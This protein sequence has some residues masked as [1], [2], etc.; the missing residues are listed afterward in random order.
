MGIAVRK[1]EWQGSAGYPMRGKSMQLSFCPQIAQIIVD[2]EVRDCVDRDEKRKNHGGTETR[3]ERGGG[4]SNGENFFLSGLCIDAADSCSPS[5]IPRHPV[6]SFIHHPLSFPFTLRASVSPWFSNPQI[7]QISTEELMQ[8]CI[9]TLGDCGHRGYFF[10]SAHR[11]DSHHTPAQR[12]ASI[13][14]ICG[15]SV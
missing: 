14:E 6:S 2:G 5:L 7:S 8:A 4:G 15:S 12:S 1:G 3:R 9:A 11:P 10:I 13:C